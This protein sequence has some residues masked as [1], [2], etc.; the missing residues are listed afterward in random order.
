MALGYKP[1]Y[2][3]FGWI[4]QLPDL[5]KGEQED[6]QIKAA[7]GD[8]GINWD[9]PKQIETIANTLGKIGTD[10]SLTLS[11]KLGEMANKRRE[12]I[13]TEQAGKAAT[14]FLGGQPA[15]GGAPMNI[16]SGPMG[17]AI[18]RHS[19]RTGLPV[20]FVAATIGA[21]SAGNPRA[22]SPAGAQGAMQLM[23]R[24]AQA[25]GVT[26]PFDPEENIRG[27]TDELA[28]LWQKYKGNPGLVAAASNWGQGN[29]DKLLSG[30]V[31][32]LP[33]ETEGHVLKVTGRPFRT[34]LEAAQSPLKQSTILAEEAGRQYKIESER[35][36]E[37]A[38]GA[39]A[40]LSGYGAK[41]PPGA[42]EAL[43]ET[44][45]VE[46]SRQSEEL[47]ADSKDFREYQAE[48]FKKRG[49]ASGLT[50][51][52]DRAERLVNDPRTIQG[53][54]ADTTTRI[55][56]FIGTLAQT[57]KQFGVDLDQNALLGRV[58]GS[59][60]RTQELRGLSNQIVLTM[61]GGKLGGQVSNTDRT[62]VQEAQ[63]S[64]SNSPEA[65]RMLIK[66]ARAFVQRDKE[67]AELT[68]AYY[69]AGGRSRA[70]LERVLQRHAEANPIFSDADKA[71]LAAEKAKAQGGGGQQPPPQAQ[72]TARPPAPPP[73]AIDALRKDPSKAADFDAYY[74]AGASDSILGR[75]SM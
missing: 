71:V 1:S 70:G 64:L 47:K 72:P 35:P 8:K 30:Q 18:Q 53:Q 40:L 37:R 50:G 22:V 59:V 17:D 75:R 56:S 12:N 45:K 15:G 28:S 5:V 31:K 61:L 11:M 26:N 44:Q 58:M 43:G 27:G 48:V 39:G 4:G 34:W 13:L 74:G 46:L 14:Q 41:L 54:G 38:R 52:L 42:K 32:G 66:A 10:K 49:E 67:V 9:D 2:I 55:G 23:P 60:D 51:L 6:R 68:Q 73:A 36:S 25:R 65:N 3:D 29:L 21:E 62:F 57:A 33:A 20:D 63:A 69:N 7:F 19:A 16:L 24:T